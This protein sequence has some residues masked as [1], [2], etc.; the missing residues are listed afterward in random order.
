MLDIRQVTEDFAVAPQITSEDMAALKAAGFTRIIANRPD[1]E[2]PGQPTL[3]DMRRAAEAEGLEFHA[4]PIRQPTPEAVE[5]TLG[6]LKQSDAKTFAFC[7]SGTR[8]VTL[9]AMAMLQSGEMTR[10]EALA[11]AQKAGYSIG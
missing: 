2:E 10:E 11:A 1:G 4:I 9:W 3:E 8:S 6:L 5:A 7:R